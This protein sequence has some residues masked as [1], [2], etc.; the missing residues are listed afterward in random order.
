[1]KAYLRLVALLTC[2][3][4]CSF[5]T[6]SQTYVSNSDSIRRLIAIAPTPA[7]QAQYLADLG[8]ELRKNPD[9]FDVAINVLYQ[10]IDMAPQNASATSQAYNTLGLI[11]KKKNEPNIA[12][13]HFRSALRIRSNAGD[14]LGTAGVSINL[15]R[16]SKQ[17][18]NYENA[19]AHFEK[20]SQIYRYKFDS[21]RLARA[22]N[23]TGATLRTIGDY[24]ESHKKLTEALTIRK[25]L[26]DTLE[27]GRSFLNLG[28]LLVDME[29]YPEAIEY[30]KEASRCFEQTNHPKDQAN[31]WTSLGA[32]YLISKNLTQARIYTQKAADLKSALGDSLGL[33]GTW[34]NMALISERDGNLEEAVEYFQRALAIGIDHH[35]SNIQLEARTNI[36]RI[37]GKSGKM[38]EADSTLT[39]A[40]EL[41]RTNGSIISQIDILKSL[42]NIAHEKN[43]DERA[44]KYLSDG[45]TL[46][47][48]VEDELMIARKI[49]HEH[50]SLQEQTAKLQNRV[51][52]NETELAHLNTLRKWQWAVILTLALLFLSTLFSGN[53]LYRKQLDRQK[54]DRR[55]EHLV[56]KSEWGAKYSRIE[57]QM[58]IKDKMGR[59]LHDL[60][61]SSLALLKLQLEAIEDHMNDLLPPEEP[62][63][64]IP[65]LKS[66]DQIGKETREIAH[67]MGQQA[68][69]ISE[70]KEF[71]KLISQSSTLE[72][73]VFPKDESEFEQL[74]SN[75]EREI[76]LS[77]REIIT[78]A[79]KHA[80]ASSMEIQF[81]RVNGS[82]HLSVSDNGIGFDPET[83]KGKK[84]MGLRS[85]ESRVKSLNGTFD[86]DSSPGNGTTI[87]IEVPI[88][89][90]EE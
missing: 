37:Q 90:K 38:D 36:G 53:L 50:E 68:G 54:A 8:W 58:E 89:T 32:A 35:N 22:L 18:G 66:L 13:G 64:V 61:G 21:T 9:S 16:L 10:A 1:M 73:K 88:K 17:L 47:A 26:N 24:P 85:I 29:E 76:S 4:I 52:T 5:T 31:A 51:K 84:G 80:K 3:L 34:I 12:M 70:I 59:L 55:I 23:L 28:N 43:D 46:Q 42:A 60:L 41:A 87:F 77:V 56:W 62:N 14:S 15:G 57:G 78:N 25:S 39:V 74:S 40:L 86:L 63:P 20:A 71:T 81:L 48:K 11:Y 6:H 33:A 19:L 67:D 49:K 69:L 27:L 75:I 30:L 45:N 79:L 82:L 7:T 44:F 83:K 72:I 2:I 65:A